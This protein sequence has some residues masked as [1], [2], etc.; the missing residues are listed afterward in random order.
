MTMNET[1]GYK[2]YATN[3][4]STETLIRNLID[5][6]S[7]SGNFLLNVGPKA[8]GT[9]PVE[10]VTGLREMGKWM[11][12]NGE[13]IYGTK[14]NPFAPFEWGRCTRKEENG[15]TILYFHVFNWPK[16]GKLVLP[17]FS[18]ELSSATMLAG[19]KKIKSTKAEGGYVLSVGDKAPDPIATVIRLEVK[20]KIE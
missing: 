11:K 6:A 3:W 1:W 5:I 4:K 9:I 18:N 19:G 8:D 7:K 20:G 16:D 13:A 2:S 12:V 17:K 14:G 10:S 15:N